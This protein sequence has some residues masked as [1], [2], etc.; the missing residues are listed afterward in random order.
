MFLT[1]S[2]SP[3]V[4]QLQ[5]RLHQRINKKTVL[6]AKN[7]TRAISIRNQKAQERRSREHVIQEEVL[8]NK[9]DMV[10]TEQV[11]ANDEYYDEEPV[12]VIAGDREDIPD[13]ADVPHHQPF[14]S[15]YTQYKVALIS[16][17]CAAPEYRRGIWESCLLDDIKH[18][19]STAEMVNKSFVV[20][21]LEV[22]NWRDPRMLKGWRN[23]IFWI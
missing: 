5:L 8:Y 23:M 7:I 3:N 16:F 15:E 11:D 17:I 22:L 19:L 2:M 10:T 4:V 13:D 18:R 20:K 1:C 12:N 21:E 6:S 14:D 9:D